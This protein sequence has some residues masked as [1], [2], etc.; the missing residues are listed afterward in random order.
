MIGNVQLDLP[1]PRTPSESPVGTEQPDGPVDAGIEFVRLRRARRYILRLRPDGRLR[2]TI[3]RGGSKAEGARFVRDQADWIARQRARVR[4]AP[5]TRQWVHGSVILVQGEP[6]VIS[7]TGETGGLIA[8]YAGRRVKL[9]PGTTDVR[10]FVERD[11]RG[12][13]GE[14]LIPRL[15]ALAAPHALALG[16]V[17]IRN[18]RSRWGSC[19]RSGRIALNFRL[20]Q[21]P[22][23]VRDYVL[24]HELMHVK[25]PN[26]S[27]R[28]WRLVEQACPGF[29]AAERWLKTEGRGLF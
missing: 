3:P 7:V 11:L 1:F 22:P 28:F 2:V 14:V 8:T 9:S 21:A 5:V 25:Q 16:R 18:Q 10:P 27:I 13:A 6:T 29:R 4:V 19:S 15:H 26:H 24:V 23:D 17:T 12:L 20:V